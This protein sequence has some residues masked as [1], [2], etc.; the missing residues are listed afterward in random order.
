MQRHKETLFPVLLPM[1]H[2]CMQA[3]EK[4]YDVLSL[5]LERLGSSEIEAMAY[6]SPCSQQYL[7]T[8]I[9]NS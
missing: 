5:S 6:I 3:R 1:S 7:I 9:I 2:G 8:I 4:G